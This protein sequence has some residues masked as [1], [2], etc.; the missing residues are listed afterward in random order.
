MRES[1]RCV[2]GR[3]I[4]AVIFGVD[5]VI[6][7]TARAS[8]TAW[9]AVLD[10]FLRSHAAT[11]EIG[12]RSFD[13]VADY[14]RHMHGR[15]RIDGVREFLASCGIEL[16]YDDLRGLAG[17]QEEI[18][19]AELGRHGVVLYASSVAAIHALRR[20]GMRTAAVSACRYATELLVSSGV[21][22]LFDAL[23]DGLDAPGTVLPEPS[24]PGLYREAALRLRQSPARTAIVEENLAAITAGRR[25][26][27]G[28]LIG[29]DRIGSASRPGGYDAVLRSRGAH[30]VISDLADLRI[31][32]AV[33]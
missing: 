8:A 15:S 11:W 21:P 32:E 23:L 3:D 6:A 7:D 25:G 22:D 2:L 33:G 1:Q 27:F 31:R 19:L 28:L 17:H 26:G 24:D 12:C 13:V 20:S 30:H 14:E 9:Q 18:F 4:N 10:P 29:I 5:G 16:T